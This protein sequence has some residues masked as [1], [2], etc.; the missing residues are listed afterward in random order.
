MPVTTR[1]RGDSNRL[2]LGVA[3]RVDEACLAEMRGWVRE[4]VGV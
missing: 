4:F 3:G 2:L 1:S